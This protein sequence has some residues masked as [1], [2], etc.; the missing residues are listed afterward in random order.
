MHRKQ[1][2]PIISKTAAMAK[3]AGMGTILLAMSCA[4][5]RT[6]PPRAAPE[7]STKYEKPPDLS[8][9]T[10]DRNM[11][12]ITDSNLVQ[13]IIEK[14]ESEER[15]DRKNAAHLFLLYARNN[16][17]KVQEAVPAMIKALQKEDDAYVRELIVLS[18]GHTGDSRAL[19]VLQGIAE[20]DPSQEVRLVAEE[21][22][23]KIPKQ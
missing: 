11:T 18:L 16:P 14:S 6:E 3:T 17:E 7:Q 8:H 20:E 2:R 13:V 5:P 19:P 21:A 9:W 15:R 22:I 23:Q 12:V 10:D 4:S 1:H